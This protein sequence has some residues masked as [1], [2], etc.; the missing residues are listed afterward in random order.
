M[1]A[2]AITV[3]PAYFSNGRT[4]HQAFIKW[5]YKNIER[6]PLY[7]TY[8]LAYACAEER[9]A[10]TIG[11]CADCKG[12]GGTDAGMCATCNGMGWIDPRFAA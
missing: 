5:G 11:K 9:V 6:C 7:T 12:N 1:N 8:Q 10:R 3:K 4:G 2:P